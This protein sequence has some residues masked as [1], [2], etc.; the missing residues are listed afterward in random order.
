MKFSKLLTTLGFLSLTLLTTPV[1]SE[2]AVCE[3]NPSDMSSV[4]EYCLTTPQNY[5]VI[6]YKLGLCT[7]DPL[8]GSS[9][10]DTS[11]N[12]VYSSSSNTRINLS[13]GSV[14][15]LKGTS[16]LPQVKQYLFAYVIMS[17]TFRLKFKYELNGITYYS[18]GGSS[19]ASEFTKNATSN[20]SEASTFI[21]TLDSFDDESND[22]L[23]NAGPISVP[24]GSI[25]ALLAK[26]DLTASANSSET[27]RLIGVFQPDQL[28]D[29]NVKSG[30]KTFDIGF[31]VEDTG[32]AVESCAPAEYGSGSSS[33][34]CGFGSGPFAPIFSLGY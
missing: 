28:K 22:H 21:E 19:L 34:V 11:C 3:T 7:A 14:L 4:N 17:P 9:F 33:V 15:N 32:G 1:R 20:A 24:G 5:E 25:K 18:K 29:I 16:V 27:V 31:T 10:S 12:T 2:E 26:A 8:T 6:I 13:P 23:A 30:L